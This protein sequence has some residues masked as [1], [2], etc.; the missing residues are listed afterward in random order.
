MT[1]E[2]E[3]PEYSSR[4]PGDL[5]VEREAYKRG[6]ADAAAICREQAKAFVPF[7]RIAGSVSIARRAMARASIKCAR[8]IDTKEGGK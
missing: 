3:A 1:S 5:R 6:L 2:D 8:A 7:R 4:C